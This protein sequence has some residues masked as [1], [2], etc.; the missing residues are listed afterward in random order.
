MNTR[1]LL[2]VTLTTLLASLGVSAQVYEYKD[3]SGRTVYTD[4]P[5]AGAAVKSRTVSRDAA[6]EPAPTTAA[7]VPKSAVDREMEFRKRQKE[8]Q[9]QSAK[10]EKEAADKAARAEACKGARQHLQLLE[11]GE[12]LATRDSAGE[13]VYIDD[14]QRAKDIERTRKQV[15]ELC[16]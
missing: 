3:A 5:P 15:S 13:R 14:D 9:E 8:A 11:S 4:Q 1:L 10:S 7:P 6:G 2:G 12:R 16:R